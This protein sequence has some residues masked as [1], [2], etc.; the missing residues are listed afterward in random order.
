MPRQADPGSA[1][2]LRSIAVYPWLACGRGIQDLRKRFDPLA[3]LVPPHATI[4]FPFAS[5]LPTED[6]RRVMEAA[7]CGMGPIRLAL[8]PPVAVEDTVQLPLGAG[9]PELRLLHD[10]MYSGI[11]QDFLRPD[12]PYRPH[13]TIGRD[14]ASA[15]R[16]ACLLEAG[17]LAGSAGLAEAIACELIGADGSSTLELV[18]P[19]SG[20]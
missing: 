6:I 13:L 18:L 19:L 3:D 10:R 16:Q 8:E 1:P 15:D 7:R 9:A 17:R 12:L 20:A 4:V 11:L 14:L 5:A 2:V